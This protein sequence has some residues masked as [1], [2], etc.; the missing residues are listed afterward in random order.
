MISLRLELDFTL[1]ITR[2]EV[3]VADRRCEIL[4]RFSFFAF[5]LRR[6]GRVATVC[7]STRFPT[8]GDG[9]NDHF[10]CKKTSCLWQEAFEV[11]FEIISLYALQASA[12][13]KRWRVQQ[14]T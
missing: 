1:P 13:I 2:R 6:S 5:P 12:S 4:L 3:T 10:G 11:A 9:V 14:P 7:V 8:D